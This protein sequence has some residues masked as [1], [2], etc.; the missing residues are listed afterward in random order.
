MAAPQPQPV[1]ERPVYYTMA[2]S[3]R[4]WSTLFAV[5]CFVIA[6]VVGVD[7]VSESGKT[8]DVLVF[9]AWGS[10]FFAAAHIPFP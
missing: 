6:L 9:L 4:F 8:S 7:W 5:V 2:A 1:P 3:W 10:A